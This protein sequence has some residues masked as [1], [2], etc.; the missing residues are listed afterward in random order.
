MTWS[1]QDRYLDEA[2]KQWAKDKEALA[3]IEADIGKGPA[4]DLTDC[5]FHATTEDFIAAL[6]AVD[7]SAS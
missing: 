1:I 6:D 7:E 5:T 2:L 3:D 4:A